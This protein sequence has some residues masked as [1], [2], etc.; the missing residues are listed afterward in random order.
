MKVTARRF[1]EFIIKNSEKEVC[2]EV[3]EKKA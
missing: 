1:F 2:K 3:C